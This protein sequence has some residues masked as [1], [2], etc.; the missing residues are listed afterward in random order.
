MAGKIL[1]LYLKPRTLNDEFKY[2]NFQINPN[3]PNPKLSF[4]NPSKIQ[5]TNQSKSFQHHKQIQ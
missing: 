1:I 3:L 4:P 5:I 2:Q